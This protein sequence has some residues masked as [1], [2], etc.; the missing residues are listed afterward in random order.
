MLPKRDT[1]IRTVYAVWAD[2]G[3]GLFRM[4]RVYGDEQEAN[5]LVES[6]MRIANR[7]G[8]KSHHYWVTDEQ[9]FD[10]PSDAVIQELTKELNELREFIAQ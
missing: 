3:D 5:S 6:E 4:I 2:Y 9:M 8:K 10:K 1:H 7:L